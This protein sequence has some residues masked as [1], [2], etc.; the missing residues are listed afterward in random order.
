MAASLGWM[1]RNGLFPTPID[2]ISFSR[3]SAHVHTHK[4]THNR[5]SG[6][7]IPTEQHFCC[8]TVSTFVPGGLGPQDPGDVSRPCVFDLGCGGLKYEGLVLGCPPSEPDLKAE[9]AVPCWL[10]QTHICGLKDDRVLS[11]PELMVSWTP[12]VLQC[13]PWRSVCRW[14][15]LALLPFSWVYWRE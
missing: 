5:F 4:Q 7:P 6:W 13:S 1:S 2:T 11:E 8:P 9:P 10:G 3:I 15:R 12:P 14:K